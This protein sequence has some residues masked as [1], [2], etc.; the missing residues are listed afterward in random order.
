MV[1]ENECPY[2]HM[3]SKNLRYP[4]CVKHGYDSWPKQS[5]PWALCSWAVRK[6]S[7]WTS[8]SVSEIRCSW[9]HC[10]WRP[11]LR[12]L[13][14]GCS[15]GDHLLASAGNC[16]LRS[17]FLSLSDIC[18]GLCKEHEAW[19]CEPQESRRGVRGHCDQREMEFVMASFR[20]YVQASY[21]GELGGPLQRVG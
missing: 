21:S 15:V 5:W 14:A 12:P 10:P 7:P 3:L 6:T 4:L 19:S 13:S 1:L 18:S 8:L 11:A 20:R 16:W 9:I 17:T 2:P